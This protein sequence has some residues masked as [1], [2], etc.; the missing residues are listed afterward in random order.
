MTTDLDL[1]PESLLP[2]RRL[3]GLLAEARLAGGYSL[4]EAA[5]ALGDPWSPVELLEVET[6]RR[7]VLDPDLEVLTDL[8]GIETTSLIPERSRLVIDLDEGVL[9]VGGHQVALGGATAQDREVLG[10]YLAMVYTMR[11]LPPGRSVPLRTPDLEVLSTALSRPTD[12]LEAELRQMMIDAGTV[13]EPRMQRLRGRVLIPAIG[14]VVAATA[15]GV[16]LLVND[17]DAAPARDGADVPAAVDV[18]V[19]DAVVQ[20]RLPDGSPGPVEVRD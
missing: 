1:P 19:G 9:G 7:P 2:P 15:A 3:G 11:D 4:V 10:Q 17:S 18:E 5:E 6:G 13:V 12:E 8:Y 20:H 16:L 14:L